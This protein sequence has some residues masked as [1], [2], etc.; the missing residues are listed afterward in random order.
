MKLKI[1]FKKELGKPTILRCIRE[2]GSETFTK[3]YPNQEIHDIAHYAV[4][5]QL[6]YQ[7]AFYGL[8]A[9]GFDIADFDLPRDQRPESLLPKNLVPQALITEHLVNLL[10]I[11]YAQPHGN[12]NIEKNLH[13]I[14][15]E[16]DLIYPNS[17]TTERILGI[18]QEL[19]G[20][21]KQWEQLP[22]KQTME[23]VFDGG[24]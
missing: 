15:K 13:L 5:Q 18:K 16:K 17:L 24:I 23:L 11:W 12:L 1:Q 4:E 10:Q 3:L 9:R 14:L 20:Y 21:M 2:D 22:N 8:L 6:G 7:H 19:L